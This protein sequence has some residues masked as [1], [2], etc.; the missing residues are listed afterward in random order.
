[1][2]QQHRR[3]RQQEDSYL[4]T[5]RTFLKLAG[6]TFLATATG[7]ATRT[8]PPVATPGIRAPTVEITL[9]ALEASWELAPGK[10]ITAW[11]YNG[12][13]PGQPIRVREG[14][15]VRVVFT[16]RL[17]EPTTIH[18]HGVDVPAAMDGVPDLSQPAIPPGATFTYEFDALPA[19]T[20][21]Y[22]THVNSARQQDL[23]LSAPFIIEPLAADLPA[24][25]EYTLLL[26][27]WITGAPAPTTTPDNNGMMGGGMM[28]GMMD[29][30][31]P[32]YDTFT[33]N[34]KAFPATAPLTVRHGERVRLRLINASNMQTFVLSLAGHPLQVTHTDG[35]PLQTPVEVDVLPIVPA[36]RYDVTFVADHPGRWPLY[37]LDQPHT[38]GGL[39]TLVVYEGSESAPE[40]ELPD[41]TP[42]LRVWSYS[43]GQGVDRLPPASGRGA[44]Y[45]L[46]LSGGMMMSADPNIWTIN[47]KVY[48]Q[49]DPLVA[50][51]NQLISVRL[52]NMSMQTHPF[53]LHGQSFRVL[54]AGG[55]TLPAPLIKDTVD[56][57]AMMGT[58]DLE[59]IAFNPGD[60]M[61]HCHK[62]M[63][64]DGGMATLIKI[65]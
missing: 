5:R 8:V 3:S 42:G 65:G 40:A 50:E 46:T 55:Q 14:E 34:G 16:N 13:V 39:K 57:P 18:W 64:M 37:A 23:G 26:D 6:T 43:L 62:P 54:R 38:Q 60:W 35:N 44:T 27:D 17:A 30:A 59:I 49:T 25:R 12:I 1:M 21:W 47:G 56:V 7:C 53:H 36:E 32:A 11:T 51:R 61:F 15:R 41:L 63:H 48:P 28:G 2:Q 10:R 9:T 52:S 29:D 31:G 22:H 58:V 45:Q 24:D 33:I 20:R 4:L 19:G